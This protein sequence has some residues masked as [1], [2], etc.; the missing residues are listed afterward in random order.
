MA[1]PCADNLREIVVLL[2][3]YGGNDR[4]VITGRLEVEFG[5]RQLQIA[6]IQLRRL[7]DETT[8]DMSAFLTDSG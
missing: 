5:N 8:V 1:K 2:S 4:P 3:N 7:F 6:N